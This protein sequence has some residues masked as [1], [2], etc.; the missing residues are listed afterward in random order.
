MTAPVLEGEASNEAPYRHTTVP[1]WLRNPVGAIIVAALIF[2][3]LGTAALAREIGRPFGGYA[4]YSLIDVGYN[5][6]AG[7]TPVWWPAVAENL[8]DYDDQLVAINGLPYRQHMW[9]QMQLAYKN[10]ENVVLDI[11]KARATD[12]SSVVITPFRFS[13]WDFL[14]LKLPNLLVAVVFWFLAVIVL[15]A[16][17][18]VTTNRVFAAG[19]ACVALQRATAIASVSVGD[20]VVPNLVAALHIFVAGHL[21]ALILHLAFVF[22]YPVHRRFRFIL[23]TYYALGF[24]SGSLLAVTRLPLWKPVPEH[25]DIFFDSAAY[26]LMVTLASSAILILIGRMVWIWFHTRESPRDRRVVGIVFVGLII[27]LPAVMIILLP[28]LPLVGTRI[29]AFLGNLDLRYFLLAVPIAF[30]LAIVRYQTFQSP[31]PLFM[32]VIALSISAFL[33]AI[34]VAV[35]FAS[36]PDGTPPTRPPFPTLITFIFVASFFWSRQADWK[37]WFGRL[38]NREDRNY[39]SARSF[40][41]RVIGRNDLRVLPAVMAQ[42]LV[43]ELELERAAVW[44][45]DANSQLFNLVATAGGQD[46]PTADRIPIKGKMVGEAVH[47][48]WP[49]TPKWLSDPA[50]QGKFEIIIPLISEGRP[51]GLLA[52]GH[53]W[54]EEI[55]DE[56]DLAVADLVGQQATLFIQAALQVEELRRVPMRVAEAQERER[57]RLASELHDTIQQF[58]GRLPFFLVVSQELMERDRLEASN[59]LDQCMTD[60]E[61]ASR[62]LRE[63][64]ANLAPNQLEVSLTKP[65]N[66]LVLHVA[67]HAGLR[68]DL[69]IPDDL[70]QITSVGTRQALYRVIQ[71]ALD[72]TVAHADATWAKVALHREDGHINFSV[73]DN[74]RGSSPTDLAMALTRGSFGLQSMRARIE[75]VGGEF[76]FETNKDRG[77]IVSGWVPGAPA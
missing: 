53:R 46:P 54:D 8:L 15:Q 62:V 22:P 70:D 29:G 63:I 61:N 11:I 2:G 65:L 12:I 28:G 60:V 57:F 7:E 77:T 10:R 75:T 71:Q 55:F 47:A 9:E 56:R 66:G 32:G 6:V 48:A 51:I 17:P 64:R 73:E 13:F 49:S 43:D 42:A 19:A 37:G 18:D 52:L 41:N 4:T 59:I 23:I 26:Q 50:M 25:L 35:W 68:V 39:E 20:S 76:Q 67:R 74:G 36:L 31:S 1:A 58:L 21:G 40:G 3:V 5:Y 72:N 69:D 14:D 30:A 27:S 38:L 44:L 34:A 16:K 33:A 24:L 45:S